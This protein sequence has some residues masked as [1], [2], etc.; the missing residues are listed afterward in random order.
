[1][2]REEKLLSLREDVKVLGDYLKEI[3]MGVMKE[4]ISRFPIFI[5]HKEPAISLGKLII[6]AEKSK[7]HWSYNAS[8]LE[9]F[10]NNEILDESQEELIETNFK[11]PKFFA[12]IFLLTPEDMDFVFCPFDLEDEEKADDV[13]KT[14]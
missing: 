6:D 14:K 10:F 4:G 11:D 12:C 5:A 7:T 2:T 3:S 13:K 8:L 1:M 9:D